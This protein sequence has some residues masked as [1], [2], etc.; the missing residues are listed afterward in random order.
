[1]ALYHLLVSW[2]SKSVGWLPGPS[3]QL[4]SRIISHNFVTVQLGYRTWPPTSVFCYCSFVFVVWCSLPIGCI[5]FRYHLFPVSLIH[6]W[7]WIGF[8]SLQLGEPL[9][10]GPGWCLC[11]C[12][13]AVFPPWERIQLLTLTVPNGKGAGGLKKKKI[14]MQPLVVSVCPVKTPPVLGRSVTGGWPVFCRFKH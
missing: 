14:T 13:V 8:E 12:L 2:V 4:L 5:S 6:S 7:P 10:G 11:V 3:F 9:P 1:M